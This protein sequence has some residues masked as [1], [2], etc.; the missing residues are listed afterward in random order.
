MAYLT[1]RLIAATAL[2]FATVG[3]GATPAAPA[4]V[5]AA[6]ADLAPAYTPDGKLKF[7]ARYR[8]GIFL[9]SGLDMSYS[10][11]PSMAGHTM[12]DNV[13]VGPA[14]Y[15]EFMRTGTWPDRTMLVLEARGG[16]SKGSINRKGTF[17][18]GDV[19]AVEVHVKDTARFGGGWAFFGFQGQDP[20]QQIPTSAECYSCH[21]KHGAVDTTM[22]QFYPTLLEVAKQKNTLSAT[23][24]P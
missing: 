22:V 1:R 6:D 16:T 10:A 18:T 17:Q 3:H 12:F 14:P 4:T 23:Y 20:A 8:E 9:S 7:P 11:S 15:R 21:Q 19:M 5:A 2:V 24:E 13:F